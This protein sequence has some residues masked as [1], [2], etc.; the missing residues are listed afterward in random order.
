MH[1]PV[2]FHKIFLTTAA[3]VSVLGNGTLMLLLMCHSS[4]QLGSYRV[5]LA[6]FAA[7]DIFISLFHAWCSQMFIMGEYGYVYFGYGTL[8]KSEPIIAHVNLV[9]SIVFF[10]P[11]YL[12]CLHFIYRY[13]SL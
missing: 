12:L 7:T 11:F 10:M 8:L 4:K 3:V 5:L 6:T 9:Y 1:I 2:L 13:L